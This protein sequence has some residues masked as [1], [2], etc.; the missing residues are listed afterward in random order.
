[1]QIKII[2]N[3]EKVIENS[4]T[5]NCS[6]DYII[7]FIG[8][9]DNVKFFEFFPDSQTHKQNWEALYNACITGNYG[10]IDWTPNNGVCYILT[11]EK[12]VE[13]CIAKYHGEGGAM[14]VRIPVE[15]CLEAFK[16]IVEKL[17]IKNY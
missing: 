1:M 10:E 2:E 16:N 3:V 11:N 9:L 17:N 6:V 12:Y 13:F 14:M 8:Y 7:S 5:E 15:N 4:T